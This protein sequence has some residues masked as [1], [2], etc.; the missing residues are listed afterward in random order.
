MLRLD[1]AP[2][3]KIIKICHY[4]AIWT[5]EIESHQEMKAGW[6]NRNSHISSAVKLLPH[7]LGCRNIHM[8]CT[9]A[10]SPF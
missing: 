10:H 8:Y 3:A 2:L 7:K 1:V 4:E 5:G 6:R 9:N